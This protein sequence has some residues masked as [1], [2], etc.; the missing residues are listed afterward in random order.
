MKQ[1]SARNLI[2]SDRP[3]GITA[4]AVLETAYVLRRL[5]GYDRAA[6][7]DALNVLLTR[8]NVVGVD[9][10]QAAAKVMLCRPSGTVSFGD[11]LLAATATSAGLSEV[12]TFDEKLRRAGLV[13]VSR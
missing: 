4:V 12:Y 6:I 8:D 2:D 9:R 11:A 10:S 13:A 5:Y 7:V 1:A 3:I